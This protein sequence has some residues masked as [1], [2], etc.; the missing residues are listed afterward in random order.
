MRLTWILF[1]ALMAAPATVLAHGDSHA[2]DPD[3]HV[4]PRVTDCEVRF[5]SEL[6]QEAFHRFVSEFGSVSAFKQ[7]GP[8]STLGR[9]GFL[10]GVEYMS[11]RVEDRSDAW[12]DTF[13]HPD[14]THELGSDHAFPKLKLQVGITDHTDL[15]L[16]FT[17]NPNSNYGWIGLDVRH[18]MLRQGP[19]MP[20]TVALRGA[21]TKTLF[22]SD[23][24]MHALSMDVSAGRLLW[25]RVTP[26]VGGGADWIVARETSSAVDLETE[27]VDEWHAMA[28]FQVM[29]WHMALG[30]EGQL[31]TVNS[32]Q[33]QVAFSY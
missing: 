12:N 20:V 4:D 26:Y 22:V 5:A 25:E 32:A 18:A 11:F 7:M 30:V 19:G 14:S 15:S 17:E 6:T 16:F 33:A 1:S 27:W 10:F 29:F 24:D 2:P 28:G 31:G 3:L 21:Y 23:M 8:P 13:V 9:R